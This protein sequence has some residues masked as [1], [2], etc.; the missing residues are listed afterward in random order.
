MAGASIIFKVTCRIDY[1][2]RNKY[3]FVKVITQLISQVIAFLNVFSLFSA[4]LMC[5][6][7]FVSEKVEMIELRCQLETQQNPT[8][9]FKA[10]SK[11]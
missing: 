7:F 2:L 8:G 4:C 6:V 5:F 10:M 1:I 9:V 11:S 3:S